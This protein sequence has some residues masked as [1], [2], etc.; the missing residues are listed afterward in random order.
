LF[1]LDGNFSYYSDSRK[2]DAKHESEDIELMFVTTVL[3]ITFYE[4]LIN[5]VHAAEL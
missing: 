3:G 5:R 2:Q 4:D 1:A